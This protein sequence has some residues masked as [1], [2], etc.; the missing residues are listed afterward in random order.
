M[1][2]MRSPIPSASHAP[3]TNVTTT[4]PGSSASKPSVKVGRT[5]PTKKPSFAAGSPS[6][7]CPSIDQ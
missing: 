3:R 4:A 2:P 6:A 7:R 5:S 1:E